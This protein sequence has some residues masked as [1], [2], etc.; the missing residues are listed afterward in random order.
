QMKSPRGSAAFSC[1]AGASASRTSVMV[2]SPCLELGR[3][4]SGRDR[5]PGLLDLL[6]PGRV[7]DLLEAAPEHPLAVEQAAAMLH[8]VV[9]HDLLPSLVACRLVGPF[10]EREGHGFAI[11][12]LHRAVEVGD[13]AMIHVVAD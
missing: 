10:N 11:L 12:G 7:E 4:G 8:A 2:R 9:L 1:S 5:R 13:L 3:Y 6:L